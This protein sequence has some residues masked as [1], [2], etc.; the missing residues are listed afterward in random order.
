MPRVLCI[1]DSS[2]NVFLQIPQGAENVTVDG[3][4]RLMNFRLGSKTQLEKE[5]L[6]F[7]GNALNVAV[8][9]ARAG[10]EVELYSIIGQDTDGERLVQF[11]FNEGSD[12]QQKT[13]KNLLKFG[14]VMQQDVKTNVGYVVNYKN[15]RFLLID[16]SIKNYQQLTINNQQMTDQ[17]W[18]FLSSVGPNYEDFFQQLLELKKE[19]GFKLAYNPSS[20]ELKKP[21]ETYLEMLKASDTLFV[22]KKEAGKIIS[23]LNSLN[24]S[25]NLSPNEDLIKKLW[26]L[27]HKLVVVTDG[28]RGSWAH[29]GKQ[30][31]YENS[32]GEVAKEKTGA[33]DAYES[34]FLAEYL[35]TGDI[36]KAM[37]SGTENAGSVIQHIGATEGLL[38]K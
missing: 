8:G 11:L 13:G 29:D 24:S 20:N 3:A 33:G 6:T 35:K 38:Y 5:V 37:K 1:G 19:K 36:Q 17:D 12:L 22:N 23:P 21:V 26:E 16:T 34:G 25:P 4:N 10:I 7:G 9:L 2:I 31:Y 14:S 27:N 18:V 32:G 28:V 15:E 30:I